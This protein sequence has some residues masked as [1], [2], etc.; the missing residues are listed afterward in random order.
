MAARSQRPAG[1][2]DAASFVGLELRDKLGGA[3]HSTVALQLWLR[4]SSCSTVV[5]KRLRTHLEEQFG[6][7]LPRFEVLA[8]VGRHPSGPTM[9]QL[10]RS[11]MVSNGNITAVVNRLIG[12]GLIM[13][14]IDGRD[15]RVVTVRLTRRG[16]AALTRMEA[17]QQR[18]VDTMFANIPE[19]R[20]RE[21]MTALADLRRS[22]ERSEL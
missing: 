11:M 3:P 15:R 18:W 13:R 17:A 14:A 5:E 19:A 10:S 6:T 2:P 20:L 12:D 8:A 9:S 1:S 21:L 22:V 16:R 4:L 7:T